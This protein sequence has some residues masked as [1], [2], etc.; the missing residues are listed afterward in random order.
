MVWRHKEVIHAKPLPQWGPCKDY[1]YYPGNTWKA[2]WWFCGSIH[3]FCS[4][5]CPFITRSR[6]QTACQGRLRLPPW[7][8][9]P[10]S[11]GV[12]EETWQKLHGQQIPSPLCHCS[13]AFKAH[14]QACVPHFRDARCPEALGADAL[15]TTSRYRNKLKAKWE[16]Q[17]KE[18]AF[19]GLRKLSRERRKGATSP[20]YLPPRDHNKV[21]AAKWAT[22]SKSTTSRQVE[23]SESRENVGGAFR[24]YPSD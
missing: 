5:S 10:L 13:R 16:M 6:P 20:K 18:T 9:L 23:P 4:G 24:H 8:F 14:K 7:V 2:S 19:Q 17:N 15:S 11:R 21:R 3:F 1:R 12:G 22:K